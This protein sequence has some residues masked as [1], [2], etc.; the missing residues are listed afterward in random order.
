MDFFL[1]ET[2]TPSWAWLVNQGLAIAII[3]GL[4]MGGW[5][6]IDWSATNLWIPLRDAAIGH[7]AEFQKTMR[8]VSKE[9]T[10]QHES[11]RGLRDK[12]NEADEKKFAAIMQ[13]HQR[14]QA[15]EVGIAKLTD[16]D[17]S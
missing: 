8:E 1:L 13:L 15:L 6:I 11:I 10:G 2:E 16:S 17:R 9:L 7:L 12:I 4:A 3:F 5:R 14:M